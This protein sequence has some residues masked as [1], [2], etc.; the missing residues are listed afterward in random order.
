ML[1][2]ADKSDDKS[3]KYVA[4]Q[5]DVKYVWGE[6]Q[7]KAF[8]DIKSCLKSDNVMLHILDVNKPF[9]LKTDASGFAISAIL[10][11]TDENNNDRV[12][13]YASRALHKGERKWSTTERE[14]CA[15]IFGVDTFN[16]FLLGSGLP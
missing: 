10:V 5:R 13:S 4:V 8:D 3:D 12:V 9:Q 14:C 2:P 16:K 11:Q 6:S 7:Q 1:A 15:V